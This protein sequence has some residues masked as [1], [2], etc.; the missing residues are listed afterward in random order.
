MKVQ[1]CFVNPEAGELFHETMAHYKFAEKVG[2]APRSALERDAQKLLD[3]F[4]D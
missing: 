3:R 4:K 1:V 2:P